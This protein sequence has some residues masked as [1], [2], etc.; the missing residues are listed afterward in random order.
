MHTGSNVIYLRLADMLRLSKPQLMG[1]DTDGY[2][3]EHG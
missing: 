2:E 1:L 3:I